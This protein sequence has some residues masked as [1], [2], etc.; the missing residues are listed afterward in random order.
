MKSVWV[1]RNKISD[2][3][4]LFPSV[5]VVCQQECQ[6]RMPVHALVQNPIV[7]GLGY[8][9]RATTKFNVPA[10]IEGKGCAKVVRRALFIR[11]TFPNV[12]MLMAS[13]LSLVCAIVIERY[14]IFLLFPAIATVGIIELLFLEKKKDWWVRIHEGP[15]G[16]G[17]WAYEFEFKDH[18]YAREFAMRNY[19]ALTDQMR[20]ELESG[21]GDENVRA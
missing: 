19:S 15:V 21:S 1:N 8:L 12:L 14:L 11:I 10:H 7:G 17:G 5:C 18:A 4:A 20:R 13:I 2:K 3:E 16:G 9:L 6:E